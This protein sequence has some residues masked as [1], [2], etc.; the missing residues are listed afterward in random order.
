MTLGG[1]HQEQRNKLAEQQL[2]WN[3]IDRNLLEPDFRVEAGN[4]PYLAAGSI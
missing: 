4:V 1:L 3:L 2:W